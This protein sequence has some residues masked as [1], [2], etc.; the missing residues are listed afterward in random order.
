MTEGAG[1]IGLA[2]GVGR[3]PDVEE[4]ILATREP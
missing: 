4:M 2:A 1:H 3:P